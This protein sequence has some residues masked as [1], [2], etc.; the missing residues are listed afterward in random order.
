MNGLDQIA[1]W[2]SENEALFSGLAAI[3]ALIAIVPAALRPIL[4]RRAT[5]NAILETGPG[6]APAGTGTTRPEESAGRPRLAV[7]PIEVT[8]GN[9]DLLTAAE[10]VT[11]EL[12]T[13]LA[14]SRG[15]EVISRRSSSVFVE[16]GKATREAGSELDVR[17]VVEGEL[18][19]TATGLRILSSLID[20]T[21]DK[22]IWSDSFETRSDDIYSVSQALAERVASHLGI[23]LTRAEVV[24]S[25]RRP[26]SRAARDL[27]LRARGIQ[28][29]EG[30]NRDSFARATE[31]L[32]EAIAAEPDDAD[33][34][35]YLALLLALSQLFGFNEAGDEHT[36]KVLHACRRAL[37]IDDPSSDV[38]GYVGCAYCDIKR[39]EQGLPLL[40][41]AVELDPSNAQAKAAL[42]TAFVGLKRFEEGAAWIEDA[43]RLTP[44]YKGNATWATV[45]V[46]AYLR[47]G[48]PDDAE[49]SIAQALRC[50]PTFFPAHLVAALVAVS[51]GD[52]E[53]AERHVLEARRINPELD[54]G[55][56]SRFLG[57]RAAGL[58]GQWI[59]AEATPA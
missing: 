31:L 56:V 23:E 34:H 7:F 39:Y 14:R 30:L 47:L 18:R 50:D 35:G 54:E 20:T 40:E 26:R 37:E 58:L 19:S 24:H 3:V 22:V 12:T 10:I 29:D 5:S 36:G 8:G 52:P 41:R 53:T 2:I 17:Y 15:C 9:D 32:E 45:L 25:R 27:V 55:T 28:F 4:R 42:G 51:K 59:G 48:R 43:L 33:A 21:R 11:V 57:R 38:L 1:T 16:S 6:A 49:A 44:A 46:G 13:L